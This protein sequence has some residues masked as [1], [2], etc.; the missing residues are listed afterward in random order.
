[1]REAVE[2]E[3]RNPMKVFLDRVRFI[4]HNKNY[5]YEPTTLQELEKLDP[6]LACNYF[7]DCFQNPA[8]FTICI[9]GSID[10]RAFAQAPTSIVKGNSRHLLGLAGGQFYIPGEKVLGIDSQH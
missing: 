3:V 2:N 4:N 6:Q 8:Q 7:N 5:F 10:V 9:T 1:M